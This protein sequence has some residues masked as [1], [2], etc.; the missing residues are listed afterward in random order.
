[1]R[2][3][4]QITSVSDGIIWQAQHAEN[5]GA[6][7]TARVV[8]ALLAVIEQDTETGRRIKNWPGPVRED[9]MA[10]RLAGGLHNLVL[11]GTDTRLADV[12][13]GTLTNQ[14]AI[15]ALI[16]ELV[17]RY[18]TRLLP[19]LD[20]P[21][22]TNEAG[23]SASIMAGLLWLSQRLGP[24]FSLNE[25]G[26]SAGINTM[27]ERYHYDLGGVRVGPENSPMRI[28]PE[29]RGQKPPQ[30]DVDI[31]G[32]KGCDVNPIDLRD[33]AEA[34]RLQSYVWP[35]ARERMGRIAAACDLA[36]Q[37]APN[38]LKMDAAAF[39]EHILAEPSECGVTKVLFHS[40]VWQYIPEMGRAAITAAM[41]EAGARGDAQTPLAWIMLETNR[42]T[43]RHELKLRYWNGKDSGWLLRGSAHPHGAWVAWDGAE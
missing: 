19:W 24:R 38:V 29:W 18:D 17:R 42:E 31:T 28:A 20:G 7:C 12:Y 16:C 6:P 25:I 35:E 8:R 1:M 21:P 34:L 9:A 15:D 33:E 30:A 26:A 2:R 22:Q 39:V 27:M 40:I 14:R 37:K 43:F 4:K 11:T 41:E 23:R 3:I 13:A 36:G 32:I 5:A 10:L